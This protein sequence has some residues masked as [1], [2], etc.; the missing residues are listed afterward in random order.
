M[1]FNL[2]YALYG[3]FFFLFCF[4]DG[5]SRLPVAFNQSFTLHCVHAA[6]QGWAPASHDQSL[7]NLLHFQRV[8]WTLK[9]L[10][11]ISL[12]NIHAWLSRGT[13]GMVTMVPRDCELMVLVHHIAV[14]KCVCLCVRVCVCVC[15]RTCE[16][17]VCVLRACLCVDIAILSETRGVFQNGVEREGRSLKIK[18]VRHST[19]RKSCLFESVTSGG[20]NTFWAFHHVANTP[21][22]FG[23]VM[24]LTTLVGSKLW[25]SET[26]LLAQGTVDTAVFLFCFVW[27]LVGLFALFFLI[28]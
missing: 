12:W 25:R 22:S 10:T 15:T 11:G 20:L 14:P 28:V 18:S 5:R 1:P 26:S 21:F 9:D 2:W 8:Q 17:C 23:C 3:W 27:L 24:F 19:S 7:V 16:R 6:C 4:W 13:L